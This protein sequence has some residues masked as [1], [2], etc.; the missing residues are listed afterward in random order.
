MKYRRIF[1]IVIDSFGIGAMDNAA[2]YGDVGCD[3]FGHIADKVPEIKI[4]NLIRMGLTQLHPAPV[5]TSPQPSECIGK[6]ARLN[7]KSNGKDTM[8]G[9]W[10]MM[11]LEIKTPFQTFTDTGFPKELIEALEKETGHRVIGNKAASGTEILD[12]LAEEEI[13]TGAMIVYTSSDS[14]LQICGN[15]ETF[16]L[17]ELYRCCKIARELTMKPEW[18]V[19]RVIARPY[20]GKKKGE[21][22]RTANRHDY[23]LKPY[24]KTAMDA[25]KEAGFDV[26]S[27]GK[28]RDIFDGEGITQ[29]I[30]SKSSVQGME[31]TIECLDQDFTGLCFTNLVDFDALWGHRRNPQGYAEELEKFD[32]LL[33]QFLDKMKEDDLVIVT[34]DH[35]ND[36]TFKGTDHTK[37][38]VPFLAYSPS[39]K[40]SG[41]IDDQN[42]FAVIGATIADNFGAAMPEGTIGTSILEQLE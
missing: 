42:C 14:V 17:D 1:T 9:H 15:E 18:K 5:L 4:P 30:R 32:V 40:T 33:G 22:K 41:R 29:A 8:T 23:A 36:P 3:T 13:K 35:G 34:A 27:I 21:F 31:Q 12:E 28:I 10:E 19:G 6:Y 2:D 16:G 38:R 26:I 25:L 11:G 39:M 24:G 20:V 7:E 37:E